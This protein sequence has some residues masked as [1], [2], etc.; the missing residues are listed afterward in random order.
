MLPT[1]KHMQSMIKRSGRAPLCATP[2]VDAD[3]AE[4]REPTKS[5]TSDSNHKGPLRCGKVYN[6]A[7]S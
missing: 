2:E 6:F 1:V 3:G 4:V 7:Y 5:S